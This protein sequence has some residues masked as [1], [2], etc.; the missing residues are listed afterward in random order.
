MIYVLSDLLI[1]SYSENDITLPLCTLTDV[2]LFLDEL[3]SDN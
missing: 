1:Y 2:E 3:F